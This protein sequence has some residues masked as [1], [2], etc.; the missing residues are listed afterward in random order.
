[1]SFTAKNGGLITS[2]VAD[3]CF[4]VSK[5]PLDELGFGSIS[6]TEYGIVADIAGRQTLLNT[7]SDRY[8]LISNDQIFGTVE[9]TL[10]SAGINFSVEY[11]M[12]DY[13]VFKATYILDNVFVTLPNGDKVYLKFE[14]THSYNG[15][16]Q[17]MIVLGYYR[18]VCSNGLVIPL[19]GHESDNFYIKGKHTE[20]ILE[21]VNKLME[22]LS[23]F[24]DRKDAIADR[25]RLMAERPVIKWKERIVQVFEANK[26]H[27]G[28]KDANLNAVYEKLTLEMNDRIGTGKNVEA[29]DWL[30][31]N[32]I[33]EGY[34][35]NDQVNSIKPHLRIEKDAKVIQWL[36]TNPLS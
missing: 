8:E 5:T 4:P 34:V 6:S 14:I 24:I 25:Y 29:N 15:L 11:E 21:S 28:K 36:Y 20:K 12:H 3:I 10:H 33:N 19:E 13:S 16:A 7:C 1:M 26:I 2:N 18:M 17:Y 35:Y 32:A 31:Y 30:I 23:H 22:T 9:L 27:A